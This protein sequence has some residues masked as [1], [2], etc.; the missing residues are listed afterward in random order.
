MKIEEKQIEKADPLLQEALKRAN[1]DEILRAIMLLGPEGDSEK[2][3]IEQ[4]PDPEQFADRAAYR[5]ALINSRQRQI[6]HQLGD[7]MQDLRA[8][9]LTLFGGT[10]SPTVVVEGAAREILRS[11][12]LPGVRHASLDRVIQ[13]HEPSSPERK[14][15]ASSKRAKIERFEQLLSKVPDVEPEDHDRL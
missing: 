12:D 5:Q 6:S 9:S 3:H 8:R 10:I 13:L 14:A 11:L 7:I 2:N 4:E 1:G 15:D